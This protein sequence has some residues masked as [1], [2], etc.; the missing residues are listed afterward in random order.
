MKAFTYRDAEKVED[1][2]SALQADDAVVLAGGT[3]VLNVLKSRSRPEAPR[4]VVD[5]N[6]IPG[7][8][9][10]EDDASGLRIGALARLSDI[11]QNDLVMTRYPALGT[12]ARRVAS[13]QLRNMGTIAGNICQ[14]TR[15]WYYRYPDNVFH[16]MRKG[17]KS[18]PAF[19][20]ENRFHSVFGVAR[21]VDPPCQT[22][23]P[24]HIDIAGYLSK[25]SAGDLDG[26]AR[27]LLETNPIPAITGRVCPHFCQQECNRVEFDETVG[28]KNVE[29]FVG[30]Y[31]LEHAERFFAPPAAET[32]F[33]V[34]IVG[35]GPA[36]LAAAYYLR[37]AGHAVVVYDSRE[38]AGGMLHGVPEY[39]LPTELVGRTVGALERMGIEFSLGFEV[40]RDVELAALR[41]AHDSV[42]VATG[43]WTDRSIGLPGEELTIPG[44]SFQVEARTAG[45]RLKGKRVLVIGGGA[46]AMDIAVTSMRLG[47]QEVTVA[48]LERREEMPA[49]DEEVEQALEEHVEVLPSWGPASVAALGDE[50]AKVVELIRCTSVFDESGRFSPSFDPSM[51]HRLEVDEVFLAVGQVADVAYLGS[52]ADFDGATRRIALDGRTQ[53]TSAAGLYAAGDLTS[54]PATVIHAIAA[55]RRA[56]E[57]MDEKFGATDQASDRIEDEHGGSIGAFGDKSLVALPLVAPRSA[58]VGDRT[59]LRED[60]ETLSPAA[61]VEEANRCFNCGCVATSP[62]DVAP[63]LIALDARIETTRRTV[64]AEDFFR[65]GVMTSTI[66]ER[67]EIVTAIEVPALEG[68]TRQAFRKH[69]VRGTIDFPIV[70]VACVLAMDGDTVRAARI[71]LAGV[72]PIPWR[73]TAAEAALVGRRIDAES[74]AAAGE[75]AISEALPLSGNTYVTRIASTMV[76]RAILESA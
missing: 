37:S 3:D 52:A 62:S 11:E 16:C 48:C 50:G 42:L 8:D 68:M 6:G 13:P 20:G 46:V 51:T 5:I 56:A 75:A 64:P 18:C 33:R 10:I 27:K 29:R 22:S 54:G 38:R 21:V 41:S 57:A 15:C 7:L 2:I 63:A 26:A 74:A 4:S 69:S 34:A 72:A 44:V 32:G 70:S 9:T 28:I 19:T 67:G 1:A 17:G 25:L 66:L 39:R 49:F 53:Q 58:P 35:S 73:S 31:A 65:A 40:G 59:L 36:G 61:A 14:E 47:A 76:K 12:A 30:D 43:M 55:G 71:A 45:S 24:G 23:C 60:T